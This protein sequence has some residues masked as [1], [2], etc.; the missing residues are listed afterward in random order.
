M[1]FSAKKN[2]FLFLAFSVMLFQK[3][4]AQFY[5]LPND[6]S[7]S[8]LSEQKLAAPDSSVHS[9]IKPYILFFSK[10]YEHVADTHHLFKYIVDDALLDIVFNTHV[11]KLEPKSEKFK[12][13][14]DPLL[15]LE[16]GKDLAN[17]KSGRLYTNTRGLI[18]SGSIGDRVYFETM[19]AENQSVFPYYLANQSRAG[20][21]VPGQGRWKQFKNVGFDYAFS[22]GFVSIQASKNLNLQF[23]HGK[24]KI[25]NGYRSL[26]L[27]D[28]SFNYPYARIT[29]QWFKG[30]VQYSNIYAVFMNLVPASLKVNPNAER[31]YQK[32]A[33]SFQYVSINATKRINLG[34]F[35]GLIW[36][37]G[38]TRNQQHLSWQ[39]FNP[40]I[41]SNLGSYSLNY[42]NNLLVGVDLKIK[43]SSKVNL[44]GQAMLDGLAK[45]DTIS[46]GVGFQAG[47]NY[48]DVFGLPNLFFQ[49]EFNK[50][51]K[52]AYQNPSQGWSDQ[53]Y[54]HYNQN[55]AY[56]LG[57]GNELIFIGDYKYKRFFVNGKYNYQDVF[58][59]AGGH[60]YT[61]IVTARLGYLINPAYNLNISLG[62]IYRKQNFSNFRDLNNETNYIFVALKTSLYNLYYDF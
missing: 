27:S 21:V 14:I 26:L 15:N 35:Q 18:A 42:K 5:N 40:L 19:F 3:T 23:G 39:Y 25:G 50:V 48:F 32:K 33:A 2:T 41:Y 61:N 31:L 6:Y 30:R 10:K 62:M 16:V 8:L 59:S 51:S 54:T 7:F 46:N 43:L 24:Q 34:F 12:L 29:Q 36:Q 9:G 20:S 47:L 22:S 56:T 38:D 52:T 60:Y 28:N 13:H 57:N 58:Y 1:I 44:Y 17:S 11:I 55:I 49:A 53:S 4:Q 37:A 45:V